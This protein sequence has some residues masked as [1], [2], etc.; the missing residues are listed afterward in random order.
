M[1]NKANQMDE[2]IIT[3][4]E[5]TRTIAMLGAS[6]KPERAS[7]R[8]ME[9]LLKRGYI[10][11]PVNPGQ[12]GGMILGQKVY[13]T[14]ADIPTAIDM[15]D[16]FRASDALVGIVAEVLALDALPKVIWTQLDVQDDEAMMPALAANITV[17]QDRCPKI[18]IPR[19]GIRTLA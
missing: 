2:T 13:A 14:L 18:E 4:L 3:A 8:V 1:T 10:V 11:I 17:I 9:Y 5:N 15:V 16:V 7:F 12:A 6:P 19:L